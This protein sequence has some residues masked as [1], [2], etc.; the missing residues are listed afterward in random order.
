MTDT[1][2][3]RGLRAAVDYDP[4]PDGH[5]PLSVLAADQRYRVAYLFVE[6]GWDREE[7]ADLMGIAEATVSTY[8]SRVRR[9]ART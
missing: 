2:L 4:A 8:C 1:P 3:A 5:I 9:E 6:A 7:I